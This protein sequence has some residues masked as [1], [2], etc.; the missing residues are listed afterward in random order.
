MYI[1]KSSLF[2]F[3]FKINPRKKRKK[4][5][6]RCSNCRYTWVPMNIM[7]HDKTLSSGKILY[8]LEIIQAVSLTPSTRTYCHVPHITTTR[9][10][11]A[12]YL[13]YEGS[14]LRWVYCIKVITSRASCRIYSSPP[15]VPLFSPLRNTRIT[16]AR[17]PD[18]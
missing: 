9:T 12:R 13:M 18:P 7:E 11:K 6:K 5:K 8:A 3:L 17:V 15:P 14:I 4:T 10:K 1:E 16:H 2:L